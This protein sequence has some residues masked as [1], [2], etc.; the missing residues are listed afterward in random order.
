[1]MALVLAFGAGLALAFGLVRLFA[2][3]T[4]HDRTLAAKTVLIRAVLVCAAIA[5]AAG[6]SDWLDAAFALMFAAFVLLVAVMKVFRARA[7]QTPLVRPAED[8]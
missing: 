1:M 5:V 2:G 8:A 4:L 6:R 7:F 3:P